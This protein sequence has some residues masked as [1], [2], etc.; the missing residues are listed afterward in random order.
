MRGCF[1]RL[2][3]LFV[4]VLMIRPVAFGVCIQAPDFWKLLLGL[5]PW[6]ARSGAPRAARRSFLV[7]ADPDRSAR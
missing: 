2:G 3:V 4:G 1:Y 5:T 6:A 7:P